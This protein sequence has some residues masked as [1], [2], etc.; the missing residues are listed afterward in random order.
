MDKG[1]KFLVLFLIQ[2][3]IICSSNFFLDEEHE[4]G[5]LPVDDKYQLFYWLFFARNRNPNAPVIVWLEG[6]PGCSAEMPI[7]TEHG[8]FLLPPNNFNFTKNPYSMNNDADMLFLDQPLGTGFSNC[9]D[10]N[11]IPYNEEM[12]YKDFLIAF[13]KLLTIHPE[14]NSRKF[15]FMGQ[16]YGGHYVPY[17][18]SHLLKDLSQIQ[19]IAIIIGNPFTYDM[20][21]FES[22]GDF[23]FY[24][25]L[26]D[27]FTYTSSKLSSYLCKIMRNWGLTSASQ[28]FCDM[29]LEIVI[30]QYGHWRFNPV[31]F[32]GKSYN[33]TH[34]TDFILHS[35]IMK[36]MNLTG[37]KWTD[38]N[39]EVEMR[40]AGDASLDCTPF[41][42]EIIDKGI[43]T[44]LYYGEKDIVCSWISGDNLIEHIGESFSNQV[45]S[46]PLKYW[47]TNGETKSEYRD[48]K[49]FRIMKVYNAGHVVFWRQASFGYDL[50][51]SIIND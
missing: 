15:I 10:F 39:G 11:R 48:Y 37:K 35:P 43:Q 33:T 21:V 28:M 9:D 12:A 22:Y 25:N 8:P 23:A 26:I 30:G 32:T 29:S 40:M 5:F 17:Y 42:K 45:K 18:V 46:A 20:S 14:F 24:N 13:K 4:Y 2:S 19:I 7:F 31:D 16:S 38:C 51:T 6:G 1:S 50:I 36:E 3:L 49:N 34:L 41:L 27:S 44:I 47:I